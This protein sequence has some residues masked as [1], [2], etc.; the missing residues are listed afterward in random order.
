MEKVR[1]WCGQPLDRGLLKNRT[2][3]KRWVSFSVLI[4]LLLMKTCIWPGKTS[5]IAPGPRRS[6]WVERGPVEKSVLSNDSVWIV[7]TGLW[8]SQ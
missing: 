3:Q 7:C 8:K 2:E 5:I 1:P 4:G 6:L